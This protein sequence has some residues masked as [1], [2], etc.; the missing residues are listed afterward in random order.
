MPYRIKR[1]E[2]IRA[3]VRRLA[4]EQNVQVI[5]G[6]RG[7]VTHQAA[8]AVRKSIKKARALLRLVWT[9]I[10]GKHRG[11]VIDRVYRRAARQL[12]PIRDARVAIDTLEVLVERFGERSRHPDFREIRQELLRAMK[13]EARRFKQ[14]KTAASIRPQLE[15]LTRQWKG[16]PL[17][18]KGWRVLAPGVNSAYRRARKALSTVASSPSDEKFH[19]W[20]KLTK[21]LWYDVRILERMRPEYMGGLAVK[22]EK[23][24]DHLGDDHDLV[25]LQDAAARIECGAPDEI[26]LLNG[27]VSKRHS[28]LRVKALALGEQI[29]AEKA[30]V[31][32][33]RL[34]RFWQAWRRKKPGGRWR[35]KS[36]RPASP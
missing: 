2:S 34:G 19:E 8:H 27:L 24:A 33:D 12:N 29:F 17:E 10:E 26:E 13:R 23:L 16:L 9:R 5:E 4:R 7:N 6:L 36:L 25:L 21:D 32:C 3:A 1:K 15:K 31:F 14:R 22:L 20:R 11:R 18:K 35:M 30:S 28:Q